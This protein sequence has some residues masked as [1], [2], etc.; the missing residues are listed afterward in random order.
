MPGRTNETNHH[1]KQNCSLLA[2]DFWGNDKHLI[3]IAHLIQ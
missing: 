1:V 3:F 2:C